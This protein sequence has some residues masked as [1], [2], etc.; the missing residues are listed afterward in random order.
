MSAFPP[1]IKGPAAKEKLNEL[2]D[3]VTEQISGT[4][5]TSLTIGAGAQSLVTQTSKQFAIGQTLRLTRT[6]D[7]SKWMQGACT[8]YDAAT[9]ELDVL[10]DTVSGAGTFVDWT[11]ALT[12]AAGPTGPAGADGADG[13]DGANGLNGADGVDGAG[14]MATSVTSLVTAGAGSKVFATQAGLA[15]TA[16]ARVRATSVG[17]G[18]WMEGVCASYVGT[19]LTVT[20]DLNSGTGTHADW[21]LNVAGERGAPGA[22]GGSSM[23]VGT[24][25]PVGPASGDGWF[26][27]AAARVST[28]YGTAW[29]E[30][31]SG[32]GYALDLDG[33][34]ASTTVWDIYVDCG[35]AA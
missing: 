27:S 13:A 20:M 4:S 2:W 14:Y 1:G 24:A 15:Y 12:G 17:T 19:T 5:V 25:A 16:G 18:E 32:D 33:G 35:A 10:V 34:S 21:T 30:A 23:T 11:I 7:V 3:R 22:A 31:S 9:G 6:S 8:G 26:D 29:V 28:R